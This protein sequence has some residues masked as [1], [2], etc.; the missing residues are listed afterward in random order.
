M[1]S[2]ELGVDNE[3]FKKATKEPYSFLY[4][5]EPMKKIKKNFYGNV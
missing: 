4:V 2:K 3:N 5:D 1:I